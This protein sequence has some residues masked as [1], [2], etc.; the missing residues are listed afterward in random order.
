MHTP[1]SDVVWVASWP[2]PIPRN[3][4][5]RSSSS[6]LVPAAIHQPDRECAQNCRL[7]PW[8]QNSRVAQ[9]TCT[10]MCEEAQRLSWCQP[11]SYQACP[12]T[13]HLPT[14][15]PH[16]YRTNRCSPR[17][18]SNS[19]PHSACQNCALEPQHKEKFVSHLIHRQPARTVRHTGYS[20]DIPTQSQSLK[21][22]RVSPSN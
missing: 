13:C 9:S 22:G 20:R 17:S 8:C 7:V 15:L 18:P 6:T 19:P 21:T 4:Y 11:R 5:R 16:Q 3:I 10:H 1:I 12:P 2:L 14:T